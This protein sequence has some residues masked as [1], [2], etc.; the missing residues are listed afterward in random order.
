MKDHFDDFHDDLR[1]LYEQNTQLIHFHA[2]SSSNLS[3]EQL[4][5]SMETFEEEGDEAD[6]PYDMNQNIKDDMRARLEGIVN[7]ETDVRQ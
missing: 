1:K 3:E 5:L 7:Y 4:N 2:N 6:E